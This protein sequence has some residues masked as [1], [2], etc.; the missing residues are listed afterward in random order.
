MWKTKNKKEM[1]EKEE[2]PALSPL[3]SSP[4]YSSSLV[5]HDHQQLCATPNNLW[6]ASEALT[7]T[8]LVSQYQRPGI[9]AS[10][11]LNPLVKTLELMGVK[12]PS[13]PSAAQV[14]YRL[15]KLVSAEKKVMKREQDYF[16]SISNWVSGLPNHENSRLLVEINRLTDIQIRTQEEL[17]RKQENINLQLSH[18]FQREHKVETQRAK[19]ANTVTE[20]REE[21][22]KKGEG[23]SIHLARER[24]EE[25]DASIEVINEQMIK[26][27][28]TSLKGAFV[29]YVI[30]LQTAC[31]RLKEGCDDFFD[32]VNSG[33]IYSLTKFPNEDP[34]F[35]KIQPISS[36]RFSSQNKENK[37]KERTNELIGLSN[38][39][40]REDKIPENPTEDSDY[41]GL[42]RCPE[43]M[44][45]IKNGSKSHAPFCPH[46]KKANT[47]RPESSQSITMP[48][49]MS[50]RIPSLIRAKESSVWQQ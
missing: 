14:A 5:Q 18:V 48:G 28:N 30:C 44:A 23:Q 49:K 19:R 33:T 6:N 9:V 46:Y 39:K 25:L 15:T 43:C 17:L 12:G 21:E 11:F 38:G 27:I 45:L 42:K 40:L 37:L 36:S 41:E 29:D 10:Q 47:E 50:L 26:A 20:L 13:L 22:R 31:N 8:S 1:P 2:G 35:A 32:Y 34:G 24:L 7:S 4:L 16:T 3:N